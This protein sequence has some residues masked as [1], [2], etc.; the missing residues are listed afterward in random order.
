MSTKKN[1]FTISLT[2]FGVF[3]LSG[4]LHLGTFAGLDSDF[5]FYSLCSKMI[6][7]GC[8]PYVDF[9]DHKPPLYYYMLLPGNWVGGTYIS[10]FFVQLFYVGLIN[11]LIFICGA[12]VTANF[13]FSTGLWAWLFFNLITIVQFFDYGNLNGGIVYVAT[14]FNLISFFLILNAKQ[15]FEHQ[16]VVKKPLIFSAGVFSALSFLTR[17]SLSSASI[18]ILVILYLFFLRKASV[19]NTL[20]FLCFFV[21]GFFLPLIL[22]FIV[23]GT[24]LNVLYDNLI[25]F[26]SIYA[27]LHGGNTLEVLNAKKHDL[28]QTELWLQVYALPLIRVIMAAF[29]IN[30]YDFRQKSAGQRSFWS[31]LDHIFNNPF[32]IWLILYSMIELFLVGLQGTADKN[33]PFFSVFAPLSILAAVA[34]CYIT[35]NLKFSRIWITIFFCLFFLHELKVPVPQAWQQASAVSRWPESKLIAD[36]K[37]HIKHN[38]DFFTLDYQAYIYLETNTIPPISRCYAGGYSWDFLGTRPALAKD[39]WRQLEDAAPRVVTRPVKSLL[40]DSGVKFLLNYEEFG[41]YRVSY[42]SEDIVLY[43]RKE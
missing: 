16:G 4:L 1:A 10:F 29:I 23:M 6:Y 13:S 31:Q 17:F 7:N 11:V 37:K 9:F 14:A 38:R 27:H 42:R 33:Y 43:V 36:I 40:S 18:F 12:R 2:L 22:I 26:N 21:I 28:A 20:T 41:V 34:L 35:I 32:T 25:V 8:K 30:L 15:Q 19:K 39:F 5:Q 3:I 24:P